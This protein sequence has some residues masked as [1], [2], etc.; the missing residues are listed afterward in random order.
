M[1]RSSWAISASVGGAVGL[2]LSAAAL[3]Y[4]RTAWGR[5]TDVDRDCQNTRAELLIAASQA[6]VR[7]AASGCVVRVGQWVD[8]YTGATHTNARTLDIDHVVPLREA[9]ASGA[10]AWTR[11]DRIAFANDPDGLAITAAGVNR[12]KGAQDIGSWIP[13]VDVCGY[14]DRWRAIK[15]R[16]GL[17][18]DAI[19]VDRVVALA[20]RCECVR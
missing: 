8:H 18:Y 11:A 12:S 2:V 9:W 6:P 3:P 16:Y 13:A 14:L 5:W 7:L 19:E 4:D 1:S 15:R 20:S 10:A 17:T